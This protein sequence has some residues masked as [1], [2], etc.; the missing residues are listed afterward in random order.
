MNVIIIQL[1]KSVIIKVMSLIKDEWSKKDY[2][3]FVKYLLKQS[4]LKYESFN[5]KLITTK[6]KMIG[7]RI[8]I[9]K[10]IVKD[11]RKGNYLEFLKIVG[12]TYYEE[13]LI[14]GLIVAYSGDKTLMESYI[15]K[16]DN[17]GLCD[18]FCLNAKFVGRD[19]TYFPYFLEYIKSKEEYKVRVG[20]VMILG[21]FVKDMY[22]K[23]IF[24]SIDN[25]RLDTYYVN[26]GIAWLLCE[27]YIKVPKETKEYLLKTKIN[28]WTFNKTI[29][30]IKESYRVSK[31]DKAYFETLRR[32]K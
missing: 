2:Q 5:K 17:W 23:R 20:L 25:I 31:E 27:C 10:E 4:N 30:K 22:I 6:Y 3:E 21:Y 24:K 8:P 13:V 16:I 26:M 14:E 32:T 1:E 7:I 29:S 28:K 9:L 19:D 12:N 18:Y 11:I 15:P